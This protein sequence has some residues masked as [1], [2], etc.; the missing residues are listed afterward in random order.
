M[1]VRGGLPGGVE[2]EYGRT[3]SEEV[4]HSE[5]AKGKVLVECADIERMGSGQEGPTET[6]RLYLT[7]PSSW[8]EVRPR[9][10]IKCQ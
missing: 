4:E 3:L 10:G 8:I 7:C 6:Q 2:L 1:E 5:E 9:V